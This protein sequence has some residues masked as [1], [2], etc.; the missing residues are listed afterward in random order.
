M[1]RYD[2]VMIHRVL[3]IG[4]WVFDFLFAD[5][6]YDIEGVLSCLY[7]AEAPYDIML[8]AKHLME[9]CKLDC[10]FTYTNQEHRRG[11]VLIGPVSSGAEFVN[12]F[13]HEMT[14]V[15]IAV[16]TSYGVDLTSE[17]PAYVAGDTAR[18]LVDV[19][20]ELGCVN[21]NGD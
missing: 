18:D 21:C 11:V 8:H 7:D 14:H 3:L 1:G 2:L 10:G 4:S 5:K 9:D 20:C 17:T 19:V 12:T 13:V 16:A 15:T 6:E